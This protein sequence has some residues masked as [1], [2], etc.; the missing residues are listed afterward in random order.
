MGHGDDILIHVLKKLWR[1]EH[2]RDEDEDYFPRSV[3]D[4]SVDFILASCCLMLNAIATEK[5]NDKGNV[6]DEVEKLALPTNNPPSMAARYNLGSQL[7]DICSQLGFV[8]SSGFGYQTF[9]YGSEAELR[10][11]FMF[12]VDKMP[13]E[14]EEVD[15]DPC[16]EADVVT[17]CVADVDPFCSCP[18]CLS[19]LSAYDAVRILP[20]ESRNAAFNLF[21]KANTNHTMIVNHTGRSSD[22]TT[23]TVA[24]KWEDHK[25]VTDEVK[26]VDANGTNSEQSVTDEGHLDILKGLKEEKEDKER[27]LY[28]NQQRYKTLRG[29]IIALRSDSKHLVEAIAMGERENADLRVDYERRSKMAELIGEDL[30]NLNRLKT[31]AAKSD[32]KMT[33]LR[34]EWEKARGELVTEGGDLSF[35]LEVFTAA[36]GG[37]SQWNQTLVDVTEMISKAELQL[38]RKES[39]VE[40]H[41]FAVAKMLDLRTG[42]SG[43]PTNTKR[44]Q[45]T[46]GQ[47]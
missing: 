40:K 6:L 11:L 33:A 14:K 20:R 5:D 2:G 30:E 21:S 26:T 45:P 36:R 8:D 46:R 13:I 47:A 9:L 22:V 23:V 25:S 29:D 27:E 32:E 4:F 31:R 39:A 17:E 3:A 15:E 1:Q 7:A 34:S 41:S 44:Y 10:Q 43:Y 42:D 18:I 19:D 35:Q 24:K 38:A 37:S 16:K 12:L 28:E